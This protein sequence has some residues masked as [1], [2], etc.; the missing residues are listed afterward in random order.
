MEAATDFTMWA[1]FARA[2]IT[3][4]IVMIMLM[5]A[6]VW[7]WA[8]IIDKIRQYRRA[9]AEADVFD[10]LF[11]S[12]GWGGRGYVLPALQGKR[13]LLPRAQ[14]PGQPRGEVQT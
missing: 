1:L 6:S 8:V 14:G 12:G 7:C 5:A 13:I 2:T 10:Q 9:R 11:W 4:K 3:V